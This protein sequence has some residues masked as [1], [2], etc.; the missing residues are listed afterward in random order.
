MAGTMAPGS[1]PP[2]AGSPDAGDLQAASLAA[3]NYNRIALFRA[4]LA[5]L[6]ITAS[7]ACTE[8]VDPVEPDAPPPLGMTLATD[9]VTYAGTAMVD[10][11][12]VIVETFT[13]LNGSHDFDGC[14]DDPDALREACDEPFDDVSGNG[15]F[16]AVW[17]GGFGPMRPAQDVHDPIWARALVLSHDQQYVAFVALDVVGL[18]SPRIHEARDR[19][20]ADGFDGVRLIVASSHNHQGPDT[21][22]LWGNPMRL[23]DPVSGLDPAFQARVA[24][25]IESTVRDAAAAMQPVD[26]RVGSVQMRDRSQWFNGSMFGG[27]NLT[28]KM[29]GMI[30]DGRDPI[31]VSDQLLVLQGLLDGGQ[32]A[33]TLT[34]WSGHPETRGS[35]N[36]SISSDWVGVTRTVLEERFGGMAL[37]LP[38]SL[39]GMQSALSGDL[40]LVDD[41]GVHVFAICDSEAVVDPGDLEC[42]EHAVGDDRVD[43]D[44]DIVPVWAEKDTWDFSTSHG[45]HIAEAAIDVIEAGAAVEASPIEVL[46]EPLYV[47]ID[48]FAYQLLGPFDIFDLGLDDAV[49]DPALCPRASESKLGCLETQTSQIRV[50]PIGF[51]AVPGELLPELAWGFPDNAAWAAE[52]V[53]PS[54]RGA[55]STYFPQHPEACDE[56]AFEDC[57]SRMAIGACNCLAMHAVPYRLHESEATLPLL[58]LLDTE[59]KA[60]L[61]MADNY[62][63]YIIPRPDFHRTVTL[64]SDSDGDHYEDTVSPSW[65]FAPEIQAAQARIANRR[66]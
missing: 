16:D 58:D 34:N 43:E 52:A 66:P 44:G 54:A 28:A 42:F 31:V 35:N 59:Y 30:Y 37:H 32:A 53:D 3:V 2:R 47:P 61:G 11:T 57:S 41:D 64:L 1:G 12:P 63:S 15:I 13:D 8:P 6:P 5:L 7:L 26:L 24:D 23:S 46:T 49:T 4:S 22:G 36:N 50:G 27:K 65:D 19:L 33:F 21:M 38:E 17:I 45:W 10:L 25:A 55:G 20:A 60:V 40:P 29:H 9:G 48:N 14:I 62:L 56:V 51:V 39:G 18:G